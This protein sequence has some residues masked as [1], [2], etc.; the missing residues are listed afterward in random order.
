MH[1]PAKLAAELTIVLS[2]FLTG[3]ALYGIYRGAAYL[4]VLADG[5]K[6]RTVREAA[7]WAIAQ[8]VALARTVVIAL[9]QD[10]VN[11]AKRQGRWTPEL[12]RQVKEQAVAQIESL[13]SREARQILTDLTGDLAAYLG[14]VLEAEVATAPNR[15][16]AGSGAGLRP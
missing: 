2:P 11:A 9:N 3:L 14:T 5:I 13:L 1:L 4:R 12:A 6:V 16:R 8:A 15:L 10:V 7:D